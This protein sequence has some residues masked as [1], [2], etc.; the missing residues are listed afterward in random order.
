MEK[1]YIVHYWPEIPL[2]ACDPQV[3]EIFKIFESEKKAQDK[4]DEFPDMFYYSY[5]VE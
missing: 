4:V 2:D 1:V 5:N 3:P